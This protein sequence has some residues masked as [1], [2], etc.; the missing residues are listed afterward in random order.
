MTRFHG[1]NARFEK[2]N[3]ECGGDIEFVSYNTLVCVLHFKVSERKPYA[4]TVGR[5]AKCSATTW[6]QVRRFVD[7]YGPC[8]T[9]ALDD[10]SRTYKGYQGTGIEVRYD[11]YAEEPTLAHVRG[12]EWGCA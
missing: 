4:I 12:F 11:V 8:I 6:R 7:E 5:F 1:C 10:F 2:R 9:W 3:T